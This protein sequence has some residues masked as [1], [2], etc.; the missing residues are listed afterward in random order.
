MASVLG[1][2]L[3]LVVWCMAAGL[4]LTSDDGP[5][6]TL[7]AHQWAQN[8]MGGTVGVWLP[9]PLYVVGAITRLT[10]E[11]AASA[12]VLNIVLSMAAILLVYRLGRMLFTPM[13]G[14]LA[15]LI[16]AVNP[17]HT[18]VA[19]SQFASPLWQV[20]FLTGTISVVAWHRD[21]T[22]GEIGAPPKAIGPRLH[23]VAAGLSFFFANLVRE[24]AWL[25]TLAVCGYFAA[26]MVRRRM[27]PAAFILWLILAS[28]APL[29]WCLRSYQLH[30]DFFF[31][32]RAR[33]A[34]Y[35]ASFAGVEGLLL[36][37][38]RYPLMLVI[39]AP[40][41][42][43]L[44]LWRQTRQRA[45]RARG[46]GL[47]LY[48]WWSSLALL[49]ASGA[50]GAIPTA[51]PFRI[52]LPF[53]LLASPIVA[54]GLRGLAGRHRI[55]AAILLALVIG[56]SVVTTTRFPTVL[57]TARY[58]GV[59]KLASLMRRS[60]ADPSLRNTNIIIERS[61]DIDM[62]DGRNLAALAS[63]PTQT[64]FDD[65][66]IRF[67]VEGNPLMAPF[68]ASVPLPNVWCLGIERRQSLFDYDTPVVE[69]ILKVI[70]AGVVA[71][72]NPALASKVPDTF[73]F[74]GTVGRYMVY[75][76]REANVEQFR[77][78][79][80]SID[81]NRRLFRTLRR[82]SSNDTGIAISREV[83]PRSAYA[84]VPDGQAAPFSLLFVGRQTEWVRQIAPPARPWRAPGSPRRLWL[85]LTPTA[86][87]PPDTYD[88]ALINGS[89]K[90]VL[91]LARVPLAPSKRAVL[92]AW[93]KRETS[94]KMGLRAALSF[95]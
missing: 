14:V 74:T 67:G 39:A 15:A 44:W 51:M 35:A 63:L 36:R 65:M 68:S 82:E 3:V 13:T 69:A 26:Q 40:G 86:E 17:W 2:K 4:V 73:A 81:S 80:E 32:I 57:G 60:R 94:W 77:D 9:L 62:Y 42:T 92:T 28:A 59:V 47:V 29:L 23:L 75:V 25:V 61:N 71:L 66:A 34:D 55:A 91:V 20:L 83:F 49:V 19:L 48:L 78:H 85:D 31:A 11:L 93:M 54:A 37:L 6:R 64:Y 50:A 38:A 8:P 43:A 27:R 10:G 79:L 52:V 56:Q 87:A 70:R 88:I 90:A 89:G 18:W 53:V 7:L 1:L 22:G 95:W 16:A 46:R 41:V 45:E 84:V 5:T 24:E 76:I 58:D 21:N 12:V 30:G 33:Q 72:K